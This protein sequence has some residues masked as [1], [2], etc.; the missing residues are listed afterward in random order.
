MQIYHF[1]KN[2]IKYINRIPVDDIPLILDENNPPVIEV[3]PE[4]RMFLINGDKA[5]YF[6]NIEDMKECLDDI[7]SI[8]ELEIKEN[9]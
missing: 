5:V 4:H 6:E 2:T 8:I 1:P 7:K 9:E 3:Y